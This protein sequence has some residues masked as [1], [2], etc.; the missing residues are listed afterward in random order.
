MTDDPTNRLWADALQQLKCRMLRETFNA[1]LLG[2]RVVESGQDTL[3]VGILRPG[4]LP[5]L[6]RYLRP[7]IEQTLLLVAGRPITVDFVPC[8]PEQLK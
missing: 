5:W 3:T 4:G 1:W 6:E 7:V 8:S 2:S